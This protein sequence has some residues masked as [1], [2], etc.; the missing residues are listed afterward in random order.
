VSKRTERYWELRCLNVAQKYSR[1]EVEHNMAA[2]E[3]QL[4]DAMR[5]VPQPE[6]MSGYCDP[7]APDELKELIVIAA[8]LHG[9]KLPTEEPTP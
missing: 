5:F 3:L 1:E 2:L 4:A 6:D 8:R 7:E 9:K